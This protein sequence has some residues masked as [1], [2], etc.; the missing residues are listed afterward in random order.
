M[1]NPPGKDSDERLPKNV[2]DRTE[3]T[4]G[5]HAGSATAERPAEARIHKGKYLYIR[6]SGKGLHYQ[7]FGLGCCRWPQAPFIGAG[8]SF[9]LQALRGRHGRGS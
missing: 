3:A 4:P 8:H 6:L 9:L 2:S 1:H 5:D 7:R